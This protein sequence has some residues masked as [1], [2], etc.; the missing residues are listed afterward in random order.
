VNDEITMNIPLVKGLLEE[1]E[2]NWAD[3]AREMKM[4]KSTVTRVVNFETLPGRKFIFALMNV[5]PDTTQLFVP[6][7]EIV[8]DVKNEVAA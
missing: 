7:S 8:D 6:L 4:S 2:W 1:L 3:L 5:F